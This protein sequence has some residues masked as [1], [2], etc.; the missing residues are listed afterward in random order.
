MAGRIAGQIHE[1]GGQIEQGAGPETVS[2]VMA[3]SEQVTASSSPEKI[4]L[5]VKSAMECLN[6]L[7]AEATWEEIMQTCGYNCILT[8][9]RPLE[10]AQVRRRKYSTERMFLKAEVQKPPRGFRYEDDGE[11]LVQFYIPRSFRPGMRCFCGL[12]QGLPE[13]TTASR[14]FCQCSRGFVQKYWEGILGR[15][16]GVELKETAITGVEECRFLVHL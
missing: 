10:A 4:A 6:A 11:V 2:R 7:T 3:G 12:M 8:N 1:I 15:P 13:G 14:T 5:W 16:V 9:K